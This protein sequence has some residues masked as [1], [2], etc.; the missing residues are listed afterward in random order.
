MTRNLVIISFY[1][2]EHHTWF[3][4]D[5]IWWQK[6]RNTVDWAKSKSGNLRQ[7]KD[8]DTVAVLEQDVAYRYQY[9]IRDRIKV[10]NFSIC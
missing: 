8:S 7:F 10:S 2:V 3:R 1:G 6:K 5:K 9:L 4:F